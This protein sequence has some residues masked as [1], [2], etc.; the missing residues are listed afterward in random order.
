MGPVPVAATVNVA[1]C[2]AV[3]V[4]L[5]GCDVMTGGCATADVPM[6]LPLRAITIVEPLLRMKTKVQAYVC[7]ATGPNIIETVMLPPGF[8]VNGREGPE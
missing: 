2:P 8:N 4:L 7:T 3:T 1:V 5:T 6:P